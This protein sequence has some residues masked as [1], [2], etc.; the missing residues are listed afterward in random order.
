MGS[1]IEMSGKLD[2]IIEVIG[3]K[4]A[5]ELCHKF[6]GKQVC[7][8]SAGSNRKVKP[9]SDFQSVI[10][11]IGVEAAGL[12]AQERLNLVYIPSFKAELHEQRRQEIIANYQ[13]E[14]IEDY[15]LSVG[16][17]SRRVYQIFQESGVNIPSIRAARVDKESELQITSLSVGLEEDVSGI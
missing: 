6:A 4:L 14:I 10:D 13:G 2:R 5:A 12:L 7:L 11:C 1:G 16:L 9:G 3:V 17:T 8:H 15:A